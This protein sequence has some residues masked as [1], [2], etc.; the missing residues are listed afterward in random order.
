ML[1]YGVHYSR[2]SFYLEFRMHYTIH[3]KENKKNVGSAAL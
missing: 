3:E 1:N 2:Y